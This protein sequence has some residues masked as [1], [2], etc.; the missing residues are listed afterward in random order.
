L[1]LVFIIGAFGCRLGA[2]PSLGGTTMN[3]LKEWLRNQKW[4]KHFPRPFLK[5]VF[6][7]FKKIKIN[8]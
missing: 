3:H 4:P 7:K 1:I 5:N 2:N 6:T 8:K